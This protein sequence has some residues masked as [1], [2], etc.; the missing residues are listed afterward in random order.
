MDERARRREDRALSAP[1]SGGNVWPG[2]SCPAF[3]ARGGAAEQ[4]CWY[5][6]YADF[7]LDRPR[8]LDVGVCEWPDKIEKEGLK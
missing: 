8:A 5:C 3:S 2:Q 4:T 1:N 7:H 6:T